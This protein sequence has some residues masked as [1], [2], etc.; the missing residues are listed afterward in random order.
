M[1][2]RAKNCAKKLKGL[3]LDSLLI[4][5]PINISYL[6]G[7]T[8]PSG[9]LLITAD[10]GLIYFTSFLYQEAAKK[11]KHWEVVASNNSRNI[12]TLVAKKIKSLSL[13][14]VGF[15]AKKLPFLEQKTLKRYL[16]AKRIDLIPT[17]DLV[18]GLRMIKDKQELTYIKKS[19]AITREAFE[20]IG[21][22]FDCRMSEKEL[23]LEAERFLSL[24]G[25][26]EIA[27]PSIVASGKNT[28]FPHHNSSDKKL[29]DKMLLIDL[30]SKY[31]GYCADLTRM[32]FWGKMPLLLRKI[33]AVVRK[34]RDA[35]IKKIREG[36]T[37]AE[38][39]K[40][41]RMLIDKSGWGKYFGHGVGHGIGLGV[42][43]L[44]ILGPNCQQTLKQSMVITIEPAVY[45]KNKFGVRLEEMVLVGSRKGEVISGNFHR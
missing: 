32:F 19:I 15:E 39:D 21:E 31:Y 43:E 29:T 13:K 20:F 27:F 11:I 10:A 23:G 24:K 2:L 41:A 6:S 12:F 33:Y 18:A 14:R 17:K 37:A 34:A 1:K 8:S 38:V 28:V 44:P 7:A 42:H 40:A 36:V 16:T 22:I 3:T 9:Y 45:F 26:R 4:S 25:D 30:G 35:S 5:D